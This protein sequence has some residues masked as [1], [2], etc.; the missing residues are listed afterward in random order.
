MSFRVIVDTTEFRRDIA[1]VNRGVAA[2]RETLTNTGEGQVLV[3]KRTPRRPGDPKGRV[4]HGRAI[5]NIM[6][7]RG[8]DPFAF[9]Q[10]VEDKAQTLVARHTQRAV[11]RAYV[12]ALP[13]T[14]RIKGAVRLAAFELAR[15]SRRNIISGGLGRKQLRESSAVD[16]SGG[17]R[18]LNSRRSATVWRWR[19]NVSSGKW[20]AK[21]G[22]PPPYGVASGRFL[23][24]IRHVWKLGRRAR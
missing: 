24:G 17:R 8:H 14:R 15:W 22:F 1:A 6:R 13:Q 19:R 21:Y 16:R 12:T 10:V 7:D 18:S 2:V 4:L 20:T 23:G 11:D 9:P 5:A 3:S